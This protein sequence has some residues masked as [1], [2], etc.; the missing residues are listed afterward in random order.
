MGRLALTLKNQIDSAETA[1]I[2]QRI[3]KKKA[4]EKTTKSKPG[5]F[6]L[7]PSL[8]ELHTVLFKMVV[9]EHGKYFDQMN[10]DPTL[11]EAEEMKNFMKSQLSKSITNNF[12]AQ[13][14]DNA[15]KKKKP[16]NKF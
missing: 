15:F 8:T 2:K 6:Q 3:S 13:A 12:R 11:D 4:E 10:I 5:H 9:M 1:K 7:F 14:D 16:P